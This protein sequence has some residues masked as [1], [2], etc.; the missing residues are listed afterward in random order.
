MGSRGWDPEDG[1]P[2][3]GIPGWDSARIVFA[4]VGLSHVPRSGLWGCCSRG[5]VSSSRDVPRSVV[6]VLHVDLRHFQESGFFDRYG[7]GDVVRSRP[8]NERPSL[9]V[10][11]PNSRS[12]YC[13]AP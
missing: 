8:C 12:A 2:G 4:G 7:L 5:V 6:L 11:H 3:D 10:G 1:I 13:W 9:I